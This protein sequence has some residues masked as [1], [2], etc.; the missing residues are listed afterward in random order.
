MAFIIKP[1][2][3]AYKRNP[4]LYKPLDAVPEKCG[5]RTHLYNVGLLLFGCLDENIQIRMLAES[6]KYL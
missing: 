1:M 2:Y 3:K 4:V 5:G 6:L